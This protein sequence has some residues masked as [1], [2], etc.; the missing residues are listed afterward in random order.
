MRY[1]LGVIFLVLSGTLSMAQT[2]LEYKLEKNA[3]FTIK[4]DAQQVITQELDG[5]THE[6]NNN[7][8]GILEFKVLAESD[9]VYDIE[10][11]FKDLN[12][13]MISSIQGELMNIKAKEVNESDMQSQVFN[14]LLNRPVKIVLTKTGDILEVNGGDSLVAKMAEA[15]GL[16]DEFSLNMMKKSLEKEFGS[17]AL[18][19]SYKQMTFIYPLE[20]VS[21][22]DSWENEYSGKLNTHNI[23]TLVALSKDNANIS[24]TADVTTDVTE[25]AATMKLSGTQ[26]T[27]ITT[28]LASGF[29]K[30]MTVK[31]FSKGTS[32]L[33]QIG[34]QEI[35]TTTQSTTTY[36][37]VNELNKP[38]NN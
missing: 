21:I 27:Q 34:N 35:P 8:N 11:T 37:L 15:S 36:E 14:S 33:A 19:N 22:G 30:K 1:I 9:S 17:E 20:K 3:T 24:G 32:T 18:S 29:I 10:L 7:I 2:T 26:N 31:G 23:W 12:L 16:E 4:Q 25:L 13:L 28:N 5:A 38:I 6:L